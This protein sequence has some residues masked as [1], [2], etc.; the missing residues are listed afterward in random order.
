MLTQ[1][2]PKKE[3]MHLQYSSLKA[4]NMSLICILYFLVIYT[5]ASDGLNWPQVC[6]ELKIA[7]PL[8]IMSKNEPKSKASIFKALSK[9]GQMMAFIYGD[10]TNLLNLSDISVISFSNEN[11]WQQMKSMKRPSLI[12]ERDKTEISRIDRPMY[13]TNGIVIK[14]RYQLKEM[15]V[16]SILGRFDGNGLLKWN[17][18]TKRNFIDRRANF[19]NISLISMTESDASKIQVPK[20]IGN[21]RNLSTILPYAYDVTLECIFNHEIWYN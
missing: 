16:F 5:K 2:F 19:Q 21:L 9:S 6:Q 20:D 17:S 7:N 18:N 8:I 14:E 12:F 11:V 3:F 10:Q 13:F 4:L 1:Y 15:E